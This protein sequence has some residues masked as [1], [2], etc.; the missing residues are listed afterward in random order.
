MNN[1]A[2]NQREAENSAEN[3]VRDGAVLP[4]TERT[5]GLDVV[6]VIPSTDHQSIDVPVSTQDYTSN[7]SVNTDHP[8]HPI[9]WS[10]SQRKHYN[11]REAA[12]K[13][14]KKKHDE[15]LNL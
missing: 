15:G 1:D 9:K 12:R 10:K 3:L 14:G 7:R 4:S 5:M 11:R 6:A 13:L 2:V 8:H